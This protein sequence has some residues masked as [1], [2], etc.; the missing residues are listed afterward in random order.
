MPRLSIRHTL[1]KLLSPELIHQVA[2]DSGAC[3]RLRKVDPFVLVW[4]LVLGSLS[5]RVRRI[6]ELRRLYQRVAAVT[7]EESSFYDRF[8]PALSAMLSTLLEH[9]LE[10]AWGAGRAAAGRLAAF[11]DILAADS[12]VI[13]VHHLLAKRFAGTRTHQGG[14]ALKAHVVFA[15]AGAGKQTVKLTAERRSDRRTFQLGP[16]VR[17]KLLLIDLGYFDYRLLARIHELGGYYIIRAKK[18]IDPIIVDRHRTHRGR[19]VQVIGQRLRSVIDK[20]HRSVLDVQVALQVRRRGYRGRRHTTP[21]F[22]RAVGVREEERRDYHI[23]LTN[24]PAE[25]L[26][27]SDIARAYALRWQIE[28]LFRELKTHYRLAQAPSK[29]PH[30]VEALIK[31]SL[32][33][34]A[35]SRAL[36]RR[37]ERALAEVDD[38]P[39]PHQRWAALFARCAHDILQCVVLERACLRIERDLRRLLLHEAPDPN[40]RTPLLAAVEQATHHY[41]PRRHHPGH[42]DSALR[43]A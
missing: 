22:V 35:A 28:L 41:G 43:A 6:C 30:I 23:Y 2:R 18:G 7:L 24:I 25:D 1:R 19:A 8:T 40:R 36:L 33:C 3:V 5:G 42:V 39:L 34:L 9:V 14:A 31:A 21:M 11:G 10:H 38:R 15:V 26:E 16:W 29:N 4:T 32:L 12:T 27:P 20:L 37:A 13:R 17:G